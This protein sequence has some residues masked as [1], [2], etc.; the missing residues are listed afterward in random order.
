MHDGT[1]SLISDMKDKIN[2]KPLADMLK[3]DS[4][5][6]KYLSTLLQRPVT[7]IAGNDAYGSVAEFQVFY[8]NS[9]SKTQIFFFISG[10]SYIFLEEQ[11]RNIYRSDDK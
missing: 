10:L 11:H 6:I 3:K 5:K 9:M 1:Q 2:K 8:K 4:I 7:I